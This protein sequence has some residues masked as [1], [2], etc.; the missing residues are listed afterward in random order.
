MLSPKTRRRLPSSTTRRG[1]RGAL[2]PRPRLGSGGGGLFVRELTSG[3]SLVVVLLVVLFGIPATIALTPDQRTTIAGQ[4][5]SVG[6]R[7]PSLSWSGPAQ[8][9]QIGNTELDV[10]PLRIVGPLRPRITLGPFQR[11]AAAEA[12]FTQPDGNPVQTAQNQLTAAFVRWYAWAAV[13]LLTITIGLVA[14]V[15]CLRMLITMR[16][17]SRAGARGGAGRAQR[18]PLTVQELWERS[19]TQVR[20]MA[21]V[22]II[23]AMGSWATCGALAYHGT[24]NGLTKVR[25]LTDLVGAYYVPPAPVG[26]VVSGYLGAVIGDSRAARQGGELVPDATEEDIVCR[27]SIDSL[28]AEIGAL[29]A[30][31][32]ANLACSGA[33]TVTGLR[34]PQIIGATEVP[35]QV[36]RLLQMSGLKFVVVA[37]GP[38][39]LGW[40]DQLLYC[41]GVADC[42][43]RL[44]EGEFN[45][46][47]AAF[48]RAYGD[49]LRDL[50]DLP[51]A[52]Q[53]IIMTSYDVFA[54]DASCEDT[55]GPPEAVGL[56]P[57]DLEL[58]ADRNR[59]LN[60]VLVAGAEKYGFSVARP[61]LTPL[62]A[63]VSRALG[64]DIQ[65][66][67]DPAPFHPTSVG[68]LRLASSV[69]QVLDSN[70]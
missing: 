26:P 52:P 25:S 42:G 48:D 38:N 7:T 36:G 69:V 57:A 23:A 47:L 19:R 30:V 55:Q 34:N 24:T 15:G 59:Q 45:Y 1:L 2:E 61:V 27:R 53:V 16:R 63:P 44:T 21:V 13:I 65:G 40:S 14:L 17:E 49:L 62:C 43:D 70:R 29:A 37:I 4:E 33:S 18:E 41:Y 64:P 60:E 28:A 56:S 20:A 39:D 9:V 67:N 35:P 3:P 66:L 46:R 32:V 8:L 12:A 54:P 10:R 68:M 22:A 6:G 11:N 5:I 50:N 31:P 58:L 51:G